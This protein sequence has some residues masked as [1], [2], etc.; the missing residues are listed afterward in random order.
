MPAPA[1]AAV[2]ALGKEGRSEHGE[3]RVG[4]EVARK[5]LGNR[6]AVA[7]GDVGEPRVP[8]RQ[9]VR[10]SP[11]QVLIAE[12]RHAANRIGPVR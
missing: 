5:T 7:D 12:W 8:R 6:G 4:V 2:S 10:M 9:S 11:V 3:A 1:V